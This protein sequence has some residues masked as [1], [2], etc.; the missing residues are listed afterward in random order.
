VPGVI[1]SF[2]ADLAPAPGRWQR[3]VFLG[4][5]TMTAVVLSWSFQVPSFAAPV[6][7]FF[8]LLPANVCTWRNLLPRLALTAA[9]ALVSIPIAGVL[10]QLPWLLLP[11]FFVGIALVA[12]FSPV[13]H[14]PL[15]LLA[16][17][18]P[19]ITACFIGVFD[20]AGMPT[21]VGDVCFGY[22][23]GIITA[24][25]FSR[26]WSADDAAATLTAAL[27]GGFALGRF[28]LH[29]VTARYSATAFEPLPGEPPLSS[30]FAR[31]M[32]LLERVRQEGRHREDVAP[33]ALAIVV[34]DRARTLTDTM[35]ALARRP[36]GR[37]YRRLLAP[38]LTAL[39]ADLDAGL[40]ACEAVTREVGRLAVN[41]TRQA[42]APW[43][44]FGAAVAA[45][46]ARQV[47]L[48]QAGAL[49]NVV[50]AEEANTDA[51]VQA[52]VD[53]SDSLHISPADLRMRSESDAQPAAGSVPR[54]DPYAARYALCVGLG[55]TISYLIGMV[56]DTPELFN[57]LWQP[58][59]LAV[60]SYGATIRRAG[61]RLAGTVIGCL[62]AITTSIAVM[63][64]VSEVP[65]LALLVLAVTVPS[66]YIAVGGPRFSYVGVQ[67][68]VAFAIVGLSDQP[69]T[70]IHSSLWRVYGT[71]LGT[72]AL[73][74]A[75]HLVG[76][77]YAG[78]QLVARFADDARG[79]LRFLPEPGAVPLTA[80]EAEGV[81]QQVVGAFPEILRLADE[82]RAEG[83]RSGADP[84][85]AVVAAGRAARI[86]YR[87][88]AVASGRS[89][90]ARP[91]LSEAMQT[92]LGTVETAIR[93]SLERALS[94][95]EA[96]H[97][98][99]RPGSR[100]YREA[101]AAAAAVAGRP[102]PDLSAALSALLRAVD[103]ARSTE[104]ADWPPAAHGVFVAE[105]EHL[106]RVIELLPSLDEYLGRMILPRT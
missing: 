6:I 101:C 54:F 17:L 96:R 80:R 33:L 9:G 29:E 59:F 100:R 81:R 87:L 25:T 46:H 56:A 74:L 45:V 94:M 16:V 43:P 104:L 19:F 58:V 66:A 4:L 73:F 57:I 49:A 106:R 63:P 75:F 21:A 34:L 7:A 70:D 61:T 11:G 48:R 102:R 55:A 38:Q 15:E 27:A 32:Q 65:A 30:Q 14:G 47:A 51:F 20:P 42:G 105:I 64:N 2:W 41:A 84:Q 79:L 44:E 89:A 77:D 90:A 78:R 67:V 8:G 37:T 103:A 83:V 82:A 60:S 35:D 68:V 5:G 62:I 72:A 24:T 71:L 28:R 93:E 26:L 23:V 36:V 13:T 99:A 1:E 91:P 10:V 98:M 97:T 95:L 76:P 39:I 3:S 18:Y 40:R 85:A 12:Y 22:A 31:E 53:L 86:A 52:L 88:A 92:A 50:I 69:G